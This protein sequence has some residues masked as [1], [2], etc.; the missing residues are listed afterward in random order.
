MNYIKI[1]METN[2]NNI[3]AGCY[4]EI[5]RINGGHSV[6]DKILSMGLLPGKTVQVISK[7]KNGPVIIKVNGTRLVVGHGVSERIHVLLKECEVNFED[8]C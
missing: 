5:L 3:K 8:R 1:S 7:Q 6:R 4:A 2:L